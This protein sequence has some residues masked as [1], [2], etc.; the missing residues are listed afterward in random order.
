MGSAAYF[1]AVAENPYIPNTFSSNIKN[2]S[3]EL[4]ITPSTSSANTQK[5]C[6]QF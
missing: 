2:G 3:E 4:V 5:H 6:Y 1:S